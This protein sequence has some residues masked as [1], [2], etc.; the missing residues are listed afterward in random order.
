MPANALN[1]FQQ[2][3][4]S[5]SLAVFNV[6]MRPLLSSSARRRLAGVLTLACLV[7]SPVRLR[8]QELYITTQGSS[9][10]FPLQYAPGSSVTFALG[11]VAVAG[12]T[13]Q[14]FH[15]F[16]PLP[17]RTDSTL[18]LTNLTVADNGNYQLQQ[19]VGSTVTASQLLTVNVLPLPPSPVDITFTA[20]VPTS[21]SPPTPV[22]HFADGSMLVYAPDNVMSGPQSR[23]PFIIRLQPNGARDPGFA[24]FAVSVSSVVLGT[25]PDRSVLLASSPYRLNPDGTS[26]P[27]T[28]PAG[29][30][31]AKPL[32]AAQAQPDGRL[33]IAQ[34]TVVVRLNADDTLDPSFSYA[35]MLGGTHTVTGFKFDLAGNIYVSAIQRDPVPGHFPTSWPIVVRLAPTGERNTVFPAQTPPLLRGSVS[36]YPL[37]DGRLL[38]YASYEGIAYWAM[39]KSD[40]SPDDSWGNVQG[41]GTSSLAGVDPA[42]FRVFSRDTYSVLQRWVITSTTLALDPTFYAGNQTSSLTQI[43]AAGRIVAAGLFQQWDGHPTSYLARLRADEVTTSFP[44]V[45][46]IGPGDVTPARGSTLTFTSLVTGT[47]PFTYQWIALDGQPLPANSTSSSLVLAH[48]SEANLGRYQLRVTG[49]AGTVLSNVTRAILG[50]S[51]SQLPYLANISGR[52]YVG[53]GDDTAIAGLAV[54]IYAGALGVPALLRGAGP[55][56]AGYGVGAYLPNPVLNLYSSTAQILANNDN[57]GGG[58]TLRD[59][60][61]STGAFPFA[62]DSNDAAMTRTFGTGNTSLQL[63]DQSNGSGVGVVE[64]Y[65]MPSNA[66]GEFTN[67]SL[68]ARTAPGER[69]ATAGFVIVDPQ[70]FGR[71]V[72]VLLRAIGPALTGYGVA[73]PL[74]DPMLTLY[75]AKGEIVTA[76]DN[77]SSALNADLTAA[78][79]AQVG[80]FPLASGSKDAAVV[81]D[82]PAGLY[83]FQ[84]RAAP[85]TPDTGVTLLEIY[86]VR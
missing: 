58:A 21:Y 25:L 5:V 13:Y 75:N 17:G 9:L 3:A 85:G 56:L 55:A 86:L 14:W 38:R 80:A 27:L 52:A 77:W 39:Y 54:K 34:D 32:T 40:G 53:T 20:E 23:Q 29:F 64:V 48:F 10:A 47:G 82:L 72:R 7:L 26:R 1:G 18:A 78:T 70:G 60:A 6:I 35:G 22:A 61:A 33:L 79:S 57:W 76:V 41:F 28:L 4:A 16:V 24:P 67:L 46:G 30:D 83:S 31:P 62:V 37:P 71:S 36:V 19:T 50:T 69:V 59:A 65:R 81:L 42:H 2:V 74:P 8:A 66:V 12:A 73:S 15:D 49:A 68:R 51:R 84:S 45:A 44:L 63:T 11:T 43:D